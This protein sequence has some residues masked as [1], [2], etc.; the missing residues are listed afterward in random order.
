MS[1]S[2]LGEHNNSSKEE[3]NSENRLKNK[4]NRFI[5][6]SLHLEGKCVEKADGPR[7]TS[8][9]RENAC[10]IFICQGCLAHARCRIEE[11]KTVQEMKD[12]SYMH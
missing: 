10:I 5:N 1:V 8:N 2:Y 3:K 9:V 11:N 4:Y 12:I 6:I 7:G